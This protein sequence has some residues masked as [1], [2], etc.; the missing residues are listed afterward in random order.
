MQDLE[1]EP[2]QISIQQTTQSL[3]K[4]TLE[5]TSK[6]NF[7]GGCFLKKKVSKQKCRLSFFVLFFT[8]SITSA[9]VSL[10]IFRFESVE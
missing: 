8:Y 5:T 3:L 4:L 2:C 6:A 9:M 7:D 1:E 10:N